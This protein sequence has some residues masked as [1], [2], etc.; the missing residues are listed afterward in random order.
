ML[1]FSCFPS[2]SIVDVFTA[3]RRLPDKLSAVDPLSVNLLQQVVDELA[4]YLTDL[5]NRS[6][7]LDQFPDMYKDAYITPLL[8]KPSLEDADVKSYRPISNLS[9][10]TKLLECLVAKQLIDY[11]KSAKLFTLYQ[12]AYRIN[13]LTKTAVLHVLS[14]ILKQLIEVTS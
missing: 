13:H 9:V 7:A 12:S 5:L 2:I 11:L 14:E 4:T 3:G 6:L 8:K 1:L 10:L